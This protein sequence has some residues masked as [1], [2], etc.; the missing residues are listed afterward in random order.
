MLND[1]LTKGKQWGVYSKI[2]LGLVSEMPKEDDV[3]KAFPHT[4]VSSNDN[5]FKFIFNFQSIV[6]LF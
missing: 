5:F 3:R 6:E 2:E 4:R 1:P